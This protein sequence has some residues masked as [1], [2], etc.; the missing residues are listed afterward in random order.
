MNMD[1]LSEMPVPGDDVI[2]ENRDI[3]IRLNEILMTEL[4]NVFDNKRNR[5]NTSKIKGTIDLIDL[6][7]CRFL[8]KLDLSEILH[9]LQYDS[10]VR[11][12][13]RI[14]EPFFGYLQKIDILLC[15]SDK[16]TSVDI[17]KIKKM[18]ILIF[19]EINNFVKMH[20]Q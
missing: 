3:I 8:Y 9:I 17:E 2:I 15:S 1:I 6:F 14:G 20:F 11:T 16:S 4:F 7:I 13:I 19:D 12:G 10:E 18:D 5:F